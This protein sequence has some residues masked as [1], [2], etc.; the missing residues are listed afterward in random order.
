MARKLPGLWLALAILPIVGCGT[1]GNF[2]A[3]PRPMVYGGVQFDAAFLAALHPG[4]TTDETIGMLVFLMLDLPLSAVG[5]TLTL[6]ITLWLENR[7]NCVPV[8]VPEPERT[9]PAVR[10]DAP[11]TAYA[12]FDATP[13]K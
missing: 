11:S 13:E 5:D 3:T 1:I 7:Q 10:Q 9:E 12:N 6:P 4:E 2:A 8:G